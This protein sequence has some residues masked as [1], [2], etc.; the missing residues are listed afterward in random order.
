MMFLFTVSLFLLVTLDT[1]CTCVSV[2]MACVFACRCTFIWKGLAGSKLIWREYE[3]GQ[4]VEQGEIVNHLTQ[5]YFEYVLRILSFI[6][7]ETHRK[8]N[9]GFASRNTDFS[10][11]K[12][13]QLSVLD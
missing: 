8:T 12:E 13:A 2:H 5:K 10:R 9:H 6:I 3:V 7:R 11:V 4:P 1:M